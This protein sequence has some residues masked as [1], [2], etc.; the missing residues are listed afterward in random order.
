MWLIML[1]VTYTWSAVSLAYRCVWRQGLVQSN[2]SYLRPFPECHSNGNWFCSGRLLWPKS[3]PLF[4]NYNL[5]YN[6]KCIFDLKFFCV[7]TDFAIMQLLYWCGALCINRSQSYIIELFQSRLNDIYNDLVYCG[8]VL[9]Q[10]T[11][12]SGFTI[13]IQ[14]IFCLG[15]WCPRL[16][17]HTGSKI[18]AAC[19]TIMAN[20]EVLLSLPT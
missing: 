9:G 2:S 3:A 5:Q 4:V 12:A 8:W 7:C 10:Y 6:C 13:E 14:R 18:A 20:V 11:K 15:S 17:V 19:S 16:Q 1:K